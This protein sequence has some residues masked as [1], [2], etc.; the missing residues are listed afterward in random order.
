[1]NTKTLNEN[2]IGDLLWA[3]E[4]CGLTTTKLTRLAKNGAIPG[5][6]NLGRGP[7]GWRFRKPEFLAWLSEQTKQN[8]TS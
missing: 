5:A 3:F 2:E 4:T 6:F 7:R 8:A 1:M